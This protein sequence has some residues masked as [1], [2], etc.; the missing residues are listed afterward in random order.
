MKAYARVAM[1]A[2]ARQRM[3]L[4]AAP[5]NARKDPKAC[6]IGDQISKSKIQESVLLGSINRPTKQSSDLTIGQ[7]QKSQHCTVW[8]SRNPMF[9]VTLRSGIVVLHLIKLTL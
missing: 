8:G 7:P 2:E 1:V 5:E 3:A 4:P 9:T 6:Q